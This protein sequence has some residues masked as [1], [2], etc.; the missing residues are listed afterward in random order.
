MRYS[1]YELRETEVVKIGLVVNEIKTK[2]LIMFNSEPRRGPHDLNLNGKCFRGVTCFKYL[3]A[4][5]SN[6]NDMKQDM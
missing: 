6:G 2:Y 5:V 1:I 4:L 3:S